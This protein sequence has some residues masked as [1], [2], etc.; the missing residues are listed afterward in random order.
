MNRRNFLKL[1]AAGAAA[2]AAA[3]ALN[4]SR[5]FTTMNNSE[6]KLKSIPQ[7]GKKVFLECGTCS[8]TFLYILN[9]EFGYPMEIEESASDPLAGGLMSTQ[10]QCGMLWGSALAVGAESFRNP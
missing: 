1:S 6:D 4:S 5:L 2:G 10:N 9:R 3:L 8:H 7:G